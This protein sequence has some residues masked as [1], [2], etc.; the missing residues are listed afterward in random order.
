M[1]NLL[2][3][4]AAAFLLAAPINSYAL[5]GKDDPDEAREKIQEGRSKILKKLYAEKPYARDEVRSA[6]G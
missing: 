1:K 6:K 5:F 3:V 2:V 4:V